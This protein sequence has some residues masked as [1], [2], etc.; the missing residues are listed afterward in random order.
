MQTATLTTG[1]L[2]RAAGVG[3]ETIR[4]YERQGLIAAP[5]SAP[6]STP[7]PA[8]CE[9]VPHHGGPDRARGG[10]ADGRKE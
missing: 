4:F 5:P 1:Q 7:V 10:G 9:P 8:G 6:S 2:A 3:R